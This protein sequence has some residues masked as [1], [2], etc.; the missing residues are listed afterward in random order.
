[1]LSRVCVFPQRLHVLSD[2]S[3][4]IPISR[5][6]FM[7]TCADLHDAGVLGEA[8]RGPPPAYLPQRCVHVPLHH[9]QDL[10]EYPQLSE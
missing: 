6:V 1:M 9:H 4:R 5:H 3:V 10:R 2:A 8:I 7:C